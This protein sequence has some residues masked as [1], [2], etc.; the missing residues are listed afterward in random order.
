MRSSISR[1]P[2]MSCCGAS[3]SGP[4]TRRRSPSPTASSVRSDV[5]LIASPRLGTARSTRPSGGSR[6]P[7]AERSRTRPVRGRPHAAAEAA[8]DDRTAPPG[9]KSRLAPGRRLKP[10]LQAR[11]SGRIGAI[12]TRPAPSEPAENDTR[13]VVEYPANG[14][15][16]SPLEHECRYQLPPRNLPVLWVGRLL[17]VK[18]APDTLEDLLADQSGEQAAEYAERYEQDLAHRVRSF[19]LD[20]APAGWLCARPTT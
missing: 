8:C 9:L 2:A 15:E 16:D 1:S 3:P 20:S 7:S 17:V 13:A 18:D 4:A 10:R 12:L 6:Q 11:R 5:P 19:M 14:P